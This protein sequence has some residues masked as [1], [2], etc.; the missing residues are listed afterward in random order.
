MKRMRLN[1]LGGA[2]PEDGYVDCHFAVT[3]RFCE[4]NGAQ[5]VDSAFSIQGGWD[6]ILYQRR[7]QQAK[8]CFIEGTDELLLS[9]SA[10]L[11][12]VEAS[13]YSWTVCRRLGGIC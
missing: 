7:L 13:L 2:A 10:S 4:G 6:L 5:N 12:E 9:D 3:N 11:Q 8:E 1:F